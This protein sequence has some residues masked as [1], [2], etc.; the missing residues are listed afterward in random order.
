MNVGRDDLGA[1][2]KTQHSVNSRRTEGSRPYVHIII[3][4]NQPCIR[5]IM[6]LHFIFSYNKRKVLQMYQILILFARPY[7]IPLNIRPLLL[8][9]RL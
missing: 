8:R 4:I 5:Y 9:K 1:P 6:S 7:H 2:C 3:Y